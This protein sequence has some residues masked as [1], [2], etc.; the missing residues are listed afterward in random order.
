MVV[1]LSLDDSADRRREIVFSVAGFIGYPGPWFEIERKWEARVKRDGISYW[2]TA[3]YISMKGE[4]RKLADRHGLT[5]ARVIADALHKDLKALIHEHPLMA[6]CLAVLMP[7]FNEVV[8]ES[9]RLHFNRDPYIFAH[10]Q[11]IGLAC[12]EVLRTKAKPVIAVTFDEH[13]KAAN[14]QDSWLDFKEKNPLCATVLGTIAPLDDKTNPCI[15]IADLIA[16]TTTNAYRHGYKDQDAV[17]AK[18]KEWLPRMQ[19]CAFVDKKYLRR[20]IAINLKEI[21]SKKK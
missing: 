13:S 21:R 2:R 12:K 5:T 20:V 3:E 15:Q 17:R 10:H 11:V 7:D 8:N 18:L 6:F 9:K 4:F 1:G 16:H 14:L 19:V